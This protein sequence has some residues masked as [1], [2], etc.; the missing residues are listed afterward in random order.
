MNSDTTAC[1]VEVFKLQ[2]K[3]AKELNKPVV[4]HLRGKSAEETSVLYD[5]AL[6]I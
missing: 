1:I 6:D 2:L 5:Q 3:L 4:I